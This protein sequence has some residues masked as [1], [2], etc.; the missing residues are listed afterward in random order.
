MIYNE[1]IVQIRLKYEW[2]YMTVSDEEKTPTFVDVNEILV[3]FCVVI[4]NA[5][6]AYLRFA[7]ETYTYIYM[8]GE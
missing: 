4:E 1:N 8:K 3:V 7:A 2:C 6:G 5:F